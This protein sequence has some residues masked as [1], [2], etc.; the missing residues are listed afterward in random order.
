[1][2]EKRKDNNKAKMKL[3]TSIICIAAIAFSA[4]ACSGGSTVDYSKAPAQTG[5]P[6]QGEWRNADGT[7]L[8]LN[9]GKY[10]YKKGADLAYTGSYKVDAGKIE[11][12]GDNGA[13]IIAS[14]PDP[15]AA[16]TVEGVAL[17][18]TD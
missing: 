9:S 17:T 5:G 6:E 12:T 7:L 13:N 2:P 4:V 1:M 18:K 10:T 14:W 3:I 16:I 8:T 15:N 11:M